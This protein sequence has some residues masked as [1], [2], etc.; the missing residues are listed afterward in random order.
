MHLL[1]WKVASAPQPALHSLT[2]PASLP[3]CPNTSYSKASAQQTPERFHSSYSE[4][5]ALQTGRSSLHYYS[6]PTAGGNVTA[7]FSVNHD[8]PSSDIQGLF[9]TSLNIP[10]AQV[11]HSQRI[12]GASENRASPLTFRISHLQFQAMASE[13]PA[14]PSTGTLHI[15][16]SI[17]HAQAFAKIATPD[18]EVID[19]LSHPSVVWAK[20]L[21]ITKEKL[22]DNNLPQLDLT[23]LTS[24]SAEEN[25]KAII[26]AINTIQKDDMKKKWR[27]SWRGKEVIVVERLRKILKGVE[28]YSKIVDTAIQVNPRVSA[29]VW[30]GVWAIVRVRT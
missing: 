7:A 27:Y 9:S 30:A 10:I 4:I 26:K 12:P 21:E 22:S 3:A 2:A 11:S 8:S 6:P 23:N 18:L 15:P 14:P 13:N 25:I 17:S 1:G 29:L 19:P 24:Q 28:K 5:S 16:T 20:V